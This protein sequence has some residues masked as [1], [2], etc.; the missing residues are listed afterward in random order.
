MDVPGE[1][2]KTRRV[3][4]RQGHPASPAVGPGDTFEHRENRRGH[5]VQM[6][7]RSRFRAVR[8]VAAT[9]HDEAVVAVE[10]EVVKRAAG[11][12]DRMTTGQDG[13]TTRLI[14]RL[15]RGDETCDGHHRALESGPQPVGVA[16]RAKQ[17]MFGLDF[18]PCGFQTPAGAMCMNAVDAGPAMN[19]GTLGDCRPGQPASVGQGL[20]VTAARVVHA[21]MVVVRSDEVLQG[22]AF[23]AFD[24]HTQFAP[25]PG[26]R[27]EEGLSMAAKPGADQSGTLVITGDAV[28]VNELEHETRCPVEHGQHGRRPVAAILCRNL[29]GQ[30]APARVD[31][32]AVSSRGAPARLSGFQHDHPLAGLGKVECRRQSG[33]ATADDSDIRTGLFGKGWRVDGRRRACG[34]QALRQLHHG[35]PRCEAQSS[36][37]AGCETRPTNLE[38]P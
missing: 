32:A 27:L 28:T 5:L 36:L 35:F 10:P 20:H 7:D 38:E 11:L 12:R 3:V 17:Q 21:D 31:L 23:Q 18:A 14:Q 37:F 15:C 24:L 22:G 1:P 29:R 26:P 13:S 19:D 34:P 33:K 4:G 2:E 25:F 6:C 8:V 30:H 16:I 9:T